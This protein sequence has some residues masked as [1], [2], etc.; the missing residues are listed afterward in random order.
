MSELT[1]LLDTAEAAAYLRMAKQT[2]AKWRSQG[3]GPSYVRLGGAV[4][5]RLSEL[6][7][8]IEAGVTSPE[9]K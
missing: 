3:R 5:Y 9:K 7:Q 6:D 8:Y 2:L 4:F 1:V